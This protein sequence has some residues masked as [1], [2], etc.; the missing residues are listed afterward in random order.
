[1]TLRSFLESFPLPVI[2]VDRQ[3]RVTLWN[4]AAERLLGW[5]AAE[6]IGKADPSVPPEVAAEHNTLW[7][8][9]FRGATAAGRESSR[10][11]RDGATLDVTIATALGHDES[12]MFLSDV[13]SQHAEE[14]RLADRETQLRLMLEQLPAIISTFDCDLVFTS[15]QGA[16]LRAL[17]LD[18]EA[19]VGRTIAEVI[20][21][22]DAP[23][24]TAIRAALRGES[25]TNEYQYRGRW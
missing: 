25:S 10:V 2:G 14:E 6:V 3:R 15:A 22:D 5:L 7:D 1:M 24:V 21:D 9:A 20:G 11:T 8:A 18:A 13:T 4:S 12:L 17:G 16:G 23:T 19:F